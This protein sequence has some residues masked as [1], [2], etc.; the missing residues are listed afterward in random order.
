MQGVSLTINEKAAF[1]K[2][3]ASS[4][5]NVSKAAQAARIARSSAYDYKKSD[6]DFSAAWDDVIEQVADAAEEELYRRAV[7]GVREPVFYKGQKVASVRKFSD[8]ALE[9]FLRANRPNKYRE[10]MELNINVPALSDEELEAI[11]KS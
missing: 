7:K 8:R 4:A 1:L 2:K 5:G 9:A 6:S 11:I 10:R 3:L